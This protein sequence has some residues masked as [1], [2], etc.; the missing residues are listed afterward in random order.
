LGEEI[1]ESNSRSRTAKEYRLLDSILQ[2]IND[3]VEEKI[4]S[5]FAE[6]NHHSNSVPDKEH[7]TLSEAAEYLGVSAATLYKWNKE[8][9]ITYTKPGGRIYYLKTDLDKFIRDKRYKVTSSDEI[10]SQ[11][12]TEV[13]TKPNMRRF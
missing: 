13:Y 5:K 6:L 10:R 1:M 7:F 9:V 4:E 2:H 8:C 12:L 11:V 3:V